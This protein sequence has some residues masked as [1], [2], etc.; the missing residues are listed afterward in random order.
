[1][2]MGKRGMT[3]KLSFMDIRMVSTLP[4]LYPA[5]NPTI[6]AI[7]LDIDEAIRAM[8]SEFLMAKV[9]CQNKSCPWEVVPNM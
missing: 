7:T 1:M 6:T 3:T 4:P 2:R 5:I 8:I 9:D